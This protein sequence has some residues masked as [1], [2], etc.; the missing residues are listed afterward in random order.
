MHIFCFLCNVHNASTTSNPK[1]VQIREFNQI[2]YFPQQVKKQKTALCLKTE[3]FLIFIILFFRQ[4]V[5]PV[6]R[7]GQNWFVPMAF[8]FL[9]SGS[10]G[11][12]CR[13]Q[14]VGGRGRLAPHFYCR[15]LE[16]STWCISLGISFP[17]VLRIFPA[18]CARVNGPKTRGA[19]APAL[20]RLER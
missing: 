13:V 5:G 2:F 14:G 3:I 16:N 18:M 9:S 1:K 20:I 8:R 12:G 19:I 17:W 11:V 6:I 7:S 4:G 15:T 10:W